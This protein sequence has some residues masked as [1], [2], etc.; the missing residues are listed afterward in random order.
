MGL[1]SAETDCA[2]GLMFANDT[3]YVVSLLTLNTDTDTDTVVR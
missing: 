3:M 1:I 2:A